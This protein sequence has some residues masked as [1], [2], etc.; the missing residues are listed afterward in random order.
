MFDRHA[1]WQKVWPQEMPRS[2]EVNQSFT[3]YFRDRASEA[4][5]AVAIDFYGREIRYRELDQYIDQFANALIRR[6]LRKGDRVALYLQN[7][8]QFVIGFFGTIRAGCIVVSLNPMFR[9][10]ELEPV[11]DKT[12]FETIIVQGSLYP[13]LRKARNFNTLKTVVVAWPSTFAPEVPALPLPTEVLEIGETFA[14]TVDFITFLAEASPTPVCRI[15]HIDT[16]PALLQLTGGTTGSPKAAVISVRAFTVAVFGSMYWFGLTAKDTSLGIA[17]FFHIMGLQVTL[18][19][20]LVSGGKLMIVTRFSPDVIA[21]AISERKCTAWVAAPTMLTA[22][23]H[24]PGVESYD[25]SSLRVIVTGGSPIPLSLQQKIQ[26]LAP[27]CQLGEGYGLTEV[28]ASGGVITP[29]GRWKPGYT[30]IPSINDVKLVDLEL[31]EKELGPHSEGEIIIKGP[32][33]M[34]GYWNDPEETR[35]AI[36]DGWFF[37]GDIGVMDDDGYLK[38]VGRKKELILCSGFNVYPSDVEDILSRHPAVLE[39]AV[40]GVPDDYRGEA[41]KAFVILKEEFRNDVKEK[42]II[43]WCKEHMAAY[44]RPRD[45]QFVESFP[46]SGAGKILKRLLVQ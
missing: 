10:M 32:T 36:R 1:C 31:G 30:G 23:V 14:E 44:K 42:E 40:A 13:E 34:N 35:K 37:T 15:Q 17:P 3:E 46:K 21:R 43:D 45:I 41:P 6:G 29:F 5:E 12:G 25:F 28:L 7:C 18:A 16:E 11:I 38:I 33:L 4:P 22:L 27:G 8:P 19:P 24:L 20:A 2:I 39:V 9:G 26:A